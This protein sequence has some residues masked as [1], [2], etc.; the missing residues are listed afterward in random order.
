MSHQILSVG[1]HR[2]ATSG[3]TPAKIVLT[4]LRGSIISPIRP[5][6]SQVRP[7]SCAWESVAAVPRVWLHYGVDRRIIDFDY[8]II[9]CGSSPPNDGPFR[10]RR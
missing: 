4:I 5:L 1:A 2:V 9:A 8:L 7:K 3:R 6:Y 10:N